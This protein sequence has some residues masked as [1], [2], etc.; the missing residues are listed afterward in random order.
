MLT[1][2]MASM[3]RCSDRS[4]FRRASKSVSSG[5]SG[6]GAGSSA[7]CSSS[8]AWAAASLTAFLLGFH[9]LLPLP[10]LLL[11]VGLLLPQPGFQVVALGFFG[12]Q[13]L[14]QHGHGL[15]ELLNLRCQGLLLL[16]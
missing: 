10:L 9:Q 2:S 8:S 5:I 1:G 4:S 7:A 15:L 11:F 16:N 12:G 13:G 6:K 3:R 14:V